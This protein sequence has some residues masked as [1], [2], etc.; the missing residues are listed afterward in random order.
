MRDIL[1]RGQTRRYGEKVRMN[2]EKLP[3]NWVYGGVLQ[4]SGD[5]SI[6]YGG[7]NADKPSEGL[8]KWPVYTDTLGQYTGLK[9]K[10]GKKIFEGDIVKQ[11]FEGTS[12]MYEGDWS[13]NSYTV[14]FEGYKIGTITFGG[15]GTFLKASRGELWM[16]GEKVEYTPSKK[17]RLAAY[18]CEVIGNIH[19]NPE[20]MKEED[21]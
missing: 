9:D 16:D 14:D 4:G 21:K 19:D 7:E 8:D 2:G 18:R 11:F 5:H 3:G 6:I 17:S 15:Y 10:N 1:F 12:T 20:L 13:E